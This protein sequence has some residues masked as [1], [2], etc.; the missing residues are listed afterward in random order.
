[1]DSTN[2]LDVY[3]RVE[4]LDEIREKVR[5][6]NKLADEIEKL[7]GSISHSSVFMQLRT[8]TDK[9]DRIHML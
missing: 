5:E 3:M 9:V 1:M 6:I 2:S 8:G 4:G 7:A